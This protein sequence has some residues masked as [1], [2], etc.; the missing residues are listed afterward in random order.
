MT[1]TPRSKQGRTSSRK[2]SNASTPVETAGDRSVREPA[3][4]DPDI[5][6]LAHE[7]F[8]ARGAEHGHDIEDWLEAERR[9]R[10]RNS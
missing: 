10:N 3:V 6:R 2:T 8:L 7:L 4:S 5:A 9:I 1:T